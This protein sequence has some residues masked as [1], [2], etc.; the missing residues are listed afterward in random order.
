M[1]I[2]YFDQESLKFKEKILSSDYPSHLM[3]GMVELEKK[4]LVKITDNVSTIPLFSKVI[5]NNPKNVLQLK[6]LRQARVFL[7]NLNSNHIMDRNKNFFRRIA[8]K[9]IYSLFDGVIC[10][11]NIQT[12][13]IREL[14]VKN[15][16][17]L[18][19]GI[20]IAG[21]KKYGH[22]GSKGEFFLSAG[23]DAGRNFDFVIDAFDRIKSEKLVVISNSEKSFKSKNVTSKSKLSYKDYLSFLASSKALVL[24]IA[25][26]SYSSDCSGSITCLE[27]V[28][29]G[30]RVLINDL[31][32]LMD[33]LPKGT[34]FVYHSADDLIKLIKN[35]KKADLRFDIR[36]FTLDKFNQK[37]INFVDGL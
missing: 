24:N 6:L 20:D 26:E 16:V 23:G 11:S 5:I 25:D 3:Y 34:F 1:V 18:P 29:M 35:F 21:I 31:P 17:A 14:G 9:W 28:L 33:L 27:A 36:I 37:L 22:A 13:G 19:L 8:L 30:K 15:F 7:V 32:W 4:G 12:K 2:Y 10:L